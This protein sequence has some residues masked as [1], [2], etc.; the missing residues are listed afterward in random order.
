MG[1]GVRHKK[2][3]VGKG[4]D[5]VIECEKRRRGTIKEEGHD[6]SN[7]SWDACY[8]ITEYKGGNQPLGQSYR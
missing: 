6:L 2:K 7:H 4:Q 5:K 1:L 3:M 8:R